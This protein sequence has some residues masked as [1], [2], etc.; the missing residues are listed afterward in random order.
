VFS[1]TANQGAII[2]IM[3][4]LTVGNGAAELAS[5]EAPC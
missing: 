5:G 3:T 2:A 1:A 4:E